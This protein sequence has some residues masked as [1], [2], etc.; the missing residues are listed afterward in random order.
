MPLRLE[1]KTADADWHP[2]TS[3]DHLVG[4]NSFK[5]KLSAYQE[6]M[7]MMSRTD[8]RMECKTKEIETT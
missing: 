4:R 6:F 3:K 1:I 7:L 2:A 5:D 8:T